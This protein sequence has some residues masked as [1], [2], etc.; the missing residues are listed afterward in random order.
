MKFLLKLILPVLLLGG[1]N[2]MAQPF[3]DQPQSGPGFSTSPSCESSICASDPYCC[4][5][6]WDGICASSATTNANCTTCLSTYQPPCSTPPAIISNFVITLT[7]GGFQDEIGWNFADGSSTILVS[8]GPNTAGTYNVSS[9]SGPFSFSLETQGS[10]N[11]NVISYE[12]SCNGT[13]VLSGTMVGGNAN[14]FSVPS[15]T[16]L[17]AAAVQCGGSVTAPTAQSAC[18]GTITGTT[19]NATTFT[20]VGSYTINWTFNDGASGVSNY[21]QTVTVTDNTA[22]VADVATL[23]TITALCEVTA[24]TAPTATDNCDGSITATHNATLPISSNTTIT[25]TYTDASTNSST[26]TQDVVINDNTAPI[27]DVSTLT[28]ITSQCAVTALTAPTATDNCTGSITGTHNATLP[29][30]SNTTIIWTYTD[31]N[32]NSATQTQDVVINDNI[33]P[34]E[35]VAT[36]T[37]ITAQCEV[38]ALTGPTATDNCDG[39]ITG[40]HNAT[41][42][43]SSNTTII[44]TYTDAN[45]NSATQTQEVVINDNI[46]PVEDVATLTTITALCEVT[47]LTA[48]TATDNCDGSITGMHNATLPISSNTT[49]TWSYEDA[50]GNITTQTQDVV[51][52]DNIAPVEDVATLTTITAQCEVTSLTAPTATDNCTGSIAGTHNATLPISSNTTITWSYEDANGNITTQTQDVVMNDDIAPVADVASL[53]TI[54]S[55]CEVTSLTAQTATDNCDGSITGTHDATLP[56]SGTTGPTTVTWT[57]TDANGNTST[58]TQDVIINMVSVNVVVDAT[59]SELTA[60]YTVSGATYQWYNCTTQQPIAGEVGVSYVPTTNGNYSVE[61]IDGNCIFMSNCELISTVSIKETAA[62]NL[63]RIFPNPNNGNFTIET[64][65]AV[66]IEMVNAVGQV[67]LNKSFTAGVNQINI[68][69]VSSGLYL[70]SSVDTNGNRTAQRV[71]INK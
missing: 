68:E 34:V 3:C 6:Q 14:T 71:V 18:Y 12:I 66:I 57:Y 60:D 42:P 67:V 5:T 31:A 50:N 33:A 36:L 27:E 32:G 70:I 25:W 45:G 48:P 29:I 4:N 10:W 9:G 43:I 28:T 38:T 46:A 15:C 13:V 2:A 40:M 44:W 53:P 63:F 49:I 61:V 21:P 54:N 17:P 51:I 59:G 26:Q 64:G 8:G 1:F 22:P 39:P 16:N 56:I 52:N 65:T 30:S 41:L 20:S 69:N 55:S 58:Q 24:L 47:A 7:A 11:D 62:N 23:T 19:S 37:T 35:D